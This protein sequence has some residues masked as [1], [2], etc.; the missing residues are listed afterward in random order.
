MSFAPLLSAPLTVQ[1]H[2]A[3]AVIA[4]AVGPF[5][6]FRRRR[7][8][9]HKIAGYSWVGAMGATA[10]SG[11]AIESQVLTVYGR[12]GAIHLLSIAALVSL[13]IGLR[14]VF[15]GRIRAHAEMMRSLYWQALGIAGLLT[16]LPGRTMNRMFLWHS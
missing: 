14:H 7:D 1:I 6:I 3:V 10:L 5:A 13:T 16:L 2:V 11:L 12:W 9:L 15:A 8:R 4:L